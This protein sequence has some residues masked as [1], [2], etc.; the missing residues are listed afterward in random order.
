MDAIGPSRFL[1]AA[2]ALLAVSAVF[3][4]LAAAACGDDGGAK[5]PTAAPSPTL[6][7]AAA[8]RATAK[9]AGEAL[10]KQAGQLLQ[11]M[12]AANETQSDPKWPGVLTSDADLVTSA[13]ATVK[14]LAPPAGF[15]AAPVTALQAAA[16]RL[17]EGAGLLKQSVQ[18]AD[19]ALGAQAFAALS[20]G[21]G[22]LEPA[23]AGLQ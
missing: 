2:A 7:P 19:S 18:R 11:D 12:Q 22:L 3:L 4:S 9:A 16:S 15:P 21:Q 14:A 20:E 10:G 23:L 6:N 5:T 17:A 13:A 1:R 8:F